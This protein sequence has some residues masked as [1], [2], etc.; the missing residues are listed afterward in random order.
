MTDPISASEWLNKRQAQAE[1]DFASHETLVEVGPGHW[2]ISRA[3]KSCFWAEIVVMANRAITV[4]G[5]ISACTFAYCS[6]AKLPEDV[7]A[8]MARADASYYGR[9]KASIG[10]CDVGVVEFRDDVAVYD[11]KER[12][13][14]AAEEFG[15]EWAIVR[16]QYTDA[17][18]AAIS[19]IEYGYHIQVVHR[20]LHDALSEIEDDC[21]EWIYD[22]GKVT[23]IRVIYA[24]AAISRLHKLL[25]GSSQ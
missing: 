14:D 22:I 7:V 15:H 1:K 25:E 5:D 11:L 2:R 10:M 20:E 9:Q 16:T 19:S 4:W 23:S 24:L 12:I 13:N 21:Y 6:G 8:W 17:I 18:D 3:D